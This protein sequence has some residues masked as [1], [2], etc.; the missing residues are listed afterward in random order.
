MIIFDTNAVNLLPPEGPRADIIR[1]L[2]Q[3][4][5]HRVAVPWMVL[6]EMAAHQA[7]LVEYGGDVL[8]LTV[9][10]V[11]VH[12]VGCIASAVTTAIDEDEAMAVGEGI[13][14]AGP[15]RGAVSEES[16]QQH[17]RQSAAHGL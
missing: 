7:Q 16:V 3:S 6:E 5:H 4:G 9:D 1:K 17:Q 10:P 14:V 12:V 8:D 2:G 15:P 11:A 13:D